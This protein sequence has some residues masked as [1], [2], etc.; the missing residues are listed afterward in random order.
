MV[1]HWY[2]CDMHFRS[3]K[4]FCEDTTND[5]LAEPKLGWWI[6]VGWLGLISLSSKGR[7]VLEFLPPRIR[8]SCRVRKC[9]NPL[10]WRSMSRSCRPLLGSVHSACHCLLTFLLVSSLTKD[11]FYSIWLFNPVDSGF[12]SVFKMG[13]HNSNRDQKHF[14]K[15]CDEDQPQYDSSLATDYSFFWFVPF[16]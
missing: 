2:L 4:S 6:V 9:I 5:L 13:R 3:L 14:S 12:Y 8:R 7:R 1:I 16:S 15:C 10:S 11:A